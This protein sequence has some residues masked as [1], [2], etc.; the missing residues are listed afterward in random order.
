MKLGGLDLGFLRRRT[1]RTE[2]LLGQIEA[3]SGFALVLG[4]REVVQ[5]IKVAQVRGVGVPM[6]IGDP[7]PLSGIGVPRADVFGLKML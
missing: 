1:T 6:L 4:N 7:L 5:H 3:N 2:H